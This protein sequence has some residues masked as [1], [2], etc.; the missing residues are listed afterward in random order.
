MWREAGGDGGGGDGGRSQSLHPPK[1]ALL[2]AQPHFRSSVKAIVAVAS[3]KAGTVR[4]WGGGAGDERGGVEGEAGTEGHWT[5]ARERH[6]AP[7]NVALNMLVASGGSV[8][9]C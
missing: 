4:V 8:V 2:E 1:A 6:R 7:A 3:G 9:Q 5:A